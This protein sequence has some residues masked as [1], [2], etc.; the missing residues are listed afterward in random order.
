[1]IRARK[2]AR[3]HVRNSAYGQAF[4][5]LDWAL[6]QNTEAD[7]SNAEKIQLLGRH[8]FGDLWHQLGSSGPVQNPK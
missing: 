8:M 7:F 6:E 2:V 4:E 5:R 3:P 1:M